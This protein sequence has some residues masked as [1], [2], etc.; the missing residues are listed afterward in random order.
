MRRPR[1]GPLCRGVPSGAGHGAVHDVAA[2]APSAEGCVQRGSGTQRFAP[3]HE[4]LAEGC[5]HTRADGA[6][7]VRLP[8][9]MRGSVPRSGSAPGCADGAEGGRT[10]ARGSSAVLARVQSTGWI[11]RVNLTA[12]ES[13]DVKAATGHA[14]P[15]SRGMKTPRGSLRTSL[16]NR[17]SSGHPSSGVASHG[18]LRI[19]GVGSKLSRSRV[20]QFRDVTSS[21]GG[22]ATGV[23]Q[24]R[25]D[26]NACAKCPRLRR[27]RPR[28]GTSH[29]LAS[30]W[31]GGT[32]AARVRSP[33]DPAGARSARREASGHRP[34]RNGP[35]Q[36]VSEGRRARP[37]RSGGVGSSATARPPG[38]R[39][40]AR[41][42]CRSRTS[43]HRGASAGA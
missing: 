40:R 22:P 16:A 23:T 28:R 21:P 41:A 19:R 38:R 30:A 32:E 11:P 35:A 6:I 10:P 39:Y 13:I 33:A 18:H 31:R 1:T 2:T 29:V 5:S 14:A 34:A 26:A 7:R 20:Q 8:A 42:G 17:V 43:T 24:C 27:L 36:P 4:W 25:G 9:S 3:P 12:Y 37:P 15:C